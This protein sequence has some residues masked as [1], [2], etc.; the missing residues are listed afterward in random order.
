MER[1]GNTGWLLIA[2]QCGRKVFSAGTCALHIGI[3]TPGDLL[4]DKAE[5]ATET[6][7]EP[8]LSTLPMPPKR[9]QAMGLGHCWHHMPQ[10]ERSRQP[11]AS[12]LW[13]PNMPTTAYA[14]SKLAA[15]EVGARAVPKC[16]EAALLP[17]PSTTKSLLCLQPCGG[18]SIFPLWKPLERE[19]GLWQSPPITGLLEGAQPPHLLHK[20]LHQHLGSSS[21]EA[22]C[23][24]TPPALSHAGKI[25][26]ESW[27][28]PCKPHSQSTR[29]H[30]LLTP[31]LYR[32]NL[33]ESS[34]RHTQV[35]S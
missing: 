12:L 22:H 15:A 5:L 24:K 8:G 17:S 31:A 16:H 9:S 4:S 29:Q 20:Y 34:L 18:H 3:C 7:S 6:P 13:N 23:N 33:A 21:D 25:P 19:H 28:W 10:R 26:L 14:R 1:G 11:K 30:L 2:A 32:C 35:G 27:W